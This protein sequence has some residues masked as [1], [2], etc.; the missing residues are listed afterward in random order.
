MLNSIVLLQLWSIFLFFQW[1]PGAFPWNRIV[2]NI[3][4]WPIC[5]PLN[6]RNI[7]SLQS[8][9]HERAR[10]FWMKWNAEAEKV[11][12]SPLFL[13]SLCFR[14][15]ERASSWFRALLKSGVFFTFFFSAEVTHW[16]TACQFRIIAALCLTFV[17]ATPCSPEIWFQICHRLIRPFRHFP[18]CPSPLVLNTLFCLFGFVYMYVFIFRIWNNIICALSLFLSD[19]FGLA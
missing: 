16:L 6:N 2:Y 1:F 3:M 14:P 15:D 10:V 9:I 19:L 18:S 17:S 7:F 8:Y 12:S 11:A 5:D 4:P 13:W